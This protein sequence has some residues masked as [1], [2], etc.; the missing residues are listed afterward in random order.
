MD[1][2]T[3]THDDEYPQLR[4]L[5]GGLDSASGWQEDEPADPLDAI[6]L[7]AEIAE[8]ARLCD[9]LEQD[10]L[11]ITFERDP[12]GGRMRARVIDAAGQPAQDLPLEQVCSPD[13]LRLLTG[14]AG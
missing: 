3:P 12:A 6:R 1:T 9:E 4:V 13:H 2:R 10:G 14:A 11:R 5:P 7:A 8:A